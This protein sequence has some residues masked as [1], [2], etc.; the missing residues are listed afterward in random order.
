[1]VVGHAKTRHGQPL[2][3]YLMDPCYLVRLHPLC[4]LPGAHVSDADHVSEWTRLEWTE[5][6]I[7][8]AFR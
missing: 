8:Y 4:A 6:P 7:V 1:M 5:K 2:I 3:Y